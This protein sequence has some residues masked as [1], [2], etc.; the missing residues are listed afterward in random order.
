MYNARYHCVM[1]IAR[2]A[3]GQGHPIAVTRNDLVG[4]FIGHTVPKT[5]SEPS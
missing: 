5:K 1:D 2:I 4:Q 3:P